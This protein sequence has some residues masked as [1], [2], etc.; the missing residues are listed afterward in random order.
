[1]G[2]PAFS[3]FSSLP[4][5][6]RRTQVA[7]LIA[8]LLIPLLNILEIYFIKGTL[9]ALE[10]G[11]LSLADPLAVFQAAFSAR[12][13]TGQLI[14]SL[15][16]PL[17][18]LALFGRVWCSWFCPY[19]LFSEWVQN[20]RHRLGMKKWRLS[21]FKEQGAAI[22]VRLLLFVP[23]LFLTGVTGIPLLNLISAPGIISSQILVALKFGYLTL[24]AALIGALLLGEFLGNQHFW[25]RLICPNGTC[26]SLLRPRSSM[27]VVPG[28]GSC[29]DCGKCAA[30]C[31]M[32][33]D[34]RREGSSPLC[35]NCGNC[36]A[37]C[38]ENRNGATLR[39]R[40]GPGSGT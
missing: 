34:P 40:I 1:M 29:T 3:P 38:P 37:V 14:A 25:C 28:R 16:V 13:I 39:F 22:K 27:R 6:R 36:I 32:G 7:T 9:Y 30:I 31:P 35:H 20:M 19:H 2:R 24:E 26:L 23:A 33:L 11:E 5:W 4:R 10:V 18:V 15:L 21:P 17:L 8:L 12:Q